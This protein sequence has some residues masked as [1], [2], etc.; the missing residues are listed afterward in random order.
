MSR[1]FDGSNDEV[2]MADNV[3][4]RFLNSVAWSIIVFFRLEDTNNQHSC[5]VGKGGS[6]ADG[7][8][9]R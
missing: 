1:N 4:I 6:G 2:E 3:A 7:Q 8:F 5:V 9:V